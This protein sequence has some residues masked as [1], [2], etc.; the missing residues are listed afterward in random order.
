MFSLELTI[1]S[2]FEN[3]LSFTSKGASLY[4]VSLTMSCYWKA[5]IHRTL[6]YVYIFI[7]CNYS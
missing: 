2:I 6:L 5:T 3:S 4:F 7:K 1:P